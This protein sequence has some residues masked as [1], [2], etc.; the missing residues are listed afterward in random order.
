[1]NLRHLL[2]FLLFFISSIRLFSQ[3]KIVL[4]S[5]KTIE[6]KIISVTEDTIRFQFP[7]KQ[8]TETGYIESYRVFSIVYPDGKET[9]IYKY[10]TLTV[11]DRT[12]EEL[13]NFITGEQD[14][15]R[16]YKPSSAA[17]FSLLISGTTAFL[18]KGSFIII[19]VPFVTYMAFAA[20]LKP[21]IDKNSVRN[22][23]LLSNPD[24]IEGYKRIA[25]SKKNRNALWGSVIG[26][27]VGLGVYIISHSPSD[28]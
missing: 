18:L 4:I 22:P 1:M 7:E 23:G 5:G 16:G 6:G 9:V 14:A 25:K 11:N 24:Y 19:V 13:R 10:D 2:L 27:G 21:G 26:A 3:D 8:K 12:E 20:L 17:I 28:F 15:L